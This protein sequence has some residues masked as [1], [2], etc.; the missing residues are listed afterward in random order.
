MPTRAIFVTTPEETV[1]GALALLRDTSVRHLPVLDG[2]RLVGMLSDRDL[3]EYRLPVLDEVDHPALVDHLLARPVGEV[4]SRRFAV[5][6]RTQ[7]ITEA[8]DAILEHG[9][10]ALPVIDRTTFDLLGM[11]SYVDLLRIARDLI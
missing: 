10:G 3:R 2:S 1:A 5:V 4:M 8:I 6:D 7:S 9:V 11:I